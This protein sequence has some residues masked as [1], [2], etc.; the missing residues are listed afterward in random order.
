MKNRLVED[1]LK[2]AKNDID[3]SKWIMEKPI[4]ITDTAAFHCQ[5]CTEKSLKAYLEFCNK[6]INKTHN[7]SI[8]LKDCA[9]IEA[10]FLEYE[11]PVSELIFYAVNIRYPDDFYMPTIEEV[12]EGI[13]TANSI[14]DLVNNLIDGTQLL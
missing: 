9:D 3:T 4:P 2:R 10:I 8:L 11:I 12:D 6:E 7:L 13:K 1:W 5:Q 14:Y